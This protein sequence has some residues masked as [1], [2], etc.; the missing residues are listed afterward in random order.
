MGVLISALSQLTNS[1]IDAGIGQIDDL[2]TRE[3]AEGRLNSGLQKLDE[4]EGDLK[5]RYAMANRVFQGQFNMPGMDLGG[6]SPGIDPN[7]LQGQQIM[8]QYSDIPRM[9]TAVGMA[10]LSAQMGYSA[11]S[12]ALQNNPM[13]LQQQIQSEAHVSA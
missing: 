12:D 6:G 7:S 3:F 13:T 2:I 8:N 10:P 11:Y 1:L 4:W 5:Q 9:P